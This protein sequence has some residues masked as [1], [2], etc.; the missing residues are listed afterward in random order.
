MLNIIQSS[1]YV[2]II[3]SYTISRLLR[4]V[5][6]ELSPES[7]LIMNVGFVASLAGFPGQH[8][9]HRCREDLAAQTHADTLRPDTT[10]LVGDGHCSALRSI[11][12]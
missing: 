2:Y 10:L 5:L 8:Q 4:S 6:D 1:Y 9:P 12:L 3:E 7:V 11:W